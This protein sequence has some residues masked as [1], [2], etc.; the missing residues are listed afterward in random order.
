[1]TNPPKDVAPPLMYLVLE[2]TSA[3]TPRVFAE[4]SVKGISVVSAIKGMPRWWASAANAGM[5]ATSNCGFDIISKYTQQ[6]LLSNKRST[7][8]GLVRSQRRASTPKR[9]SV[10]VSSE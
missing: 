8:A 2:T 9:L 10:E 4:N 6:V 7:S 3:S 5:S 1:M